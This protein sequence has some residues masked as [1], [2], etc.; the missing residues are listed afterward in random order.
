MVLMRVG[1]K[2]SNKLEATGCVSLPLFQLKQ[3]QAGYESKGETKQTPTV[4]GL[5]KEDVEISPDLQNGII[6]NSWPSAPHVYLA[7]HHLCCVIINTR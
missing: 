4:L 7:M 6:C 3:L 2:C 1:D 5:L